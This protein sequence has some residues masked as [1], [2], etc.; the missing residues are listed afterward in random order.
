MSLPVS[1]YN[2]LKLRVAQASA[3]A[4]PPLATK[5]RAG[6]VSF[7]R[8]D[9]LPRSGERDAFPSRPDFTQRSLSPYDTKWDLWMG[10]GRSTV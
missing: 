6:R 4:M 10:Q 9:K 1:L 7:I 5:S 8:A 3:A 2:A